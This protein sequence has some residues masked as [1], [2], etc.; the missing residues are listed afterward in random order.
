MVIGLPGAG[1]AGLTAA[2][3]MWCSG[4]GPVATLLQSIFILAGS[5]TCLSQGKSPSLLGGELC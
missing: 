4:T 3:S 2:R 5:L 1:G